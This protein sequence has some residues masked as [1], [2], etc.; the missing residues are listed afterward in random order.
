MQ[1]NLTLLTDLYQLTMAQGYWQQGKLDT[2]GCF[3]LFYRENPFGGGY[4]V[5]CGTDQVAHLVEGFGFT[6]EDAAYLAEVPAPDGSPLFNR[7]FLQWL[8]GMRLSVDIDAVPDGSV[9]FPREPLVR[10]TGPLLQCQLLE[11]AILNGMNF[12]SLIATKAAR[13][14]YAC[15]GRGVAEFGLRRA[16]GPDGGMSGDRAAYVGGC[17]SVANVLAGK[18][19]GI[20]VSGTHAHSWVMSFP[21]EL[22]AFRAYAQT[23]P[24]NCTLLVDTYDVEQGVRNAIT[25][26][27]EME[28]RGQRLNGIRI[29]SGDLAWLSKRAR[30]A[31]DDAG[32]GYVGIVLS[33]DLDEYTVQ[34]LIDQGACFNAI[35]IGTKLITADPQPALGG[36][37]KL[38]AVREGARGQWVPKIK[39]SEQATKL[40]IPGV[41]D[42]RRYYHD[43]G[44]FAG[45]VVFDVHRGCPEASVAV[46]PMDDTSR[47]RFSAGQRY[48]T[49]LR[50]LV[51]DGAV[52]PEAN[53]SAH[54][55]RAVFDAQFAC[56]DDST[57]R[58]LNPHL[59]PAGIEKGL[60][61][62]RTQ[63]IIDVRGQEGMY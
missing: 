36:V 51:R 40:T 61:D 18:E 59:Y 4:A 57:K 1:C 16:Q 30:K 2:Y 20:P 19:Y 53:L 25:V 29:D 12:Q 32:L 21:D 35:G 33:N 54:A 28:A 22:T 47:K 43:D 49:L 44:T 7:E 11:T 38:S 27:K 6:D 63:M 9:V 37:Y 55:A 23:F 34:S 31:L 3:Y 17:S 5:S 56:L 26:G 48:E 39:L 52:V 42:T 13:V 45:D 58:F 60:F 14:C 62:L 10:V 46:N 15:A 24:H 41:L 50:P 8:Q